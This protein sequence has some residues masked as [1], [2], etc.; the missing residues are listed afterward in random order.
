M[1][2]GNVAALGRLEGTGDRSYGRRKR[3]YGTATGMRALH[4]RQLCVGHGG[5]CSAGAPGRDEESVI[6]KAHT[7]LPGVG[8]D[9]RFVPTIVIRQTR[10]VLQRRDDN[11]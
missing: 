5:C 8:F 9:A 4:R 2:G 3:Y 1:G 6:W 7:L 10:G 11:I